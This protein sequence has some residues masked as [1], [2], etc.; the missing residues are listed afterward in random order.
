MIKKWVEKYKKSNFVGKVGYLSLAF[1]TS[2]L[3]GAYYVLYFM[4]YSIKKIVEGVKERNWKKIISFSLIL[5]ALVGWIIGSDNEYLNKEEVVVAEENI[6]EDKKDNKE[7]NDSEI[8]NE[9]V[10]EAKFD[11]ISE[12]DKYLEEEI[13]TNLKN[14]SLQKVEYYDDSKTLGVFL[15][16]RD[17]YFSKSLIIDEAK[18]EAKDVVELIAKEYAQEEIVDKYE[19]IFMGDFID[20]FG[21]EFE[22]SA[23]FLSFNHDTLQKINWENKDY[24]DIEKVADRA[25]TH[26][27]YAE[28]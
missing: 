7:I 3:I 26:N 24:I 18:I 2:P 20:E 25:V 14:V 19:I 27:Y 23:F 15:D 10:E 11:K 5:T 21:N 6:K 4:Y 22:T 13:K 8:V 12:I 1:I 17:N 28:K 16:L 9:L